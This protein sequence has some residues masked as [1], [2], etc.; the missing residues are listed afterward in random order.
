MKQSNF[1]AML[2]RM[3][4]INRWALMRSSR[5]ETLS[6]HC[7]EVAII[8]HCLATIRNR[9]FGGNA[10]ADRAAVIGLLHDSSEIITGDLPTPVKY[11]NSDIKTAYKQLEKEADLRL[12]N[13]LPEDLREDYE[14]FF[15]PRE[16]DAELWQLC[17]AADKISALIKCTEERKMGNPEFKEAERSTLT[18]IKK[19]GV[20]EADVFIKEFLPPFGLT[21]DELNK[22]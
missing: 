15:E 8:A 18:H 12:L 4:Y 5:E 11:Y 3:K 10:D 14:P 9:R 13:M 19:L 6:E 16:G 22:E 17:K 21:L 1:F 2:F 20:P 7:L